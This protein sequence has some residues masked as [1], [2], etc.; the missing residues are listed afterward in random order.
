MFFTTVAAV[1]STI[2]YAMVPEDFQITRRLV[3][4]CLDREVQRLRLPI[5]LLVQSP[6]IRTQIV[7]LLNTFERR[8]PDEI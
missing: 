4:G 5:V 6:K 8:G 1:I 3:D 2:F 7:A